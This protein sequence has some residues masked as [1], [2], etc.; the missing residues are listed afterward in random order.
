MRRGFEV[1]TIEDIQQF[2]ERFAPAD[3]DSLGEWYTGHAHFKDPFNEVAGVEAIRRV[4]AHM[5]DT[6]AEPRFV[7]T[8][9][10]GAGEN[11]ALLWDFHFRTRA[12]GHG[13][14]VIR[15]ASHLRLADTDGR[16]EWHRDYWDAAEEFYAKVP[17]LGVLVRW[18]QARGRA[19]GRR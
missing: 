4:Y 19:S 13:V 10:I 11:W 17:M 2:F 1:K 7:V 8:E 14:Q 16:I 12:L 18:L 9:R 5:F 3:L 6:L 15:G